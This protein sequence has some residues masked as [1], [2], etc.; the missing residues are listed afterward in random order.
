VFAEQLI[1]G[2]VLGSTYALIA[3]GYALQLSILRIF[4]LAYGDIMMASTFVGYL[5]LTQTGLGHIAAALA[6]ILTGAALGLVLER[7]TLRFLPTGNELSPLMVTI[8]VGTLLVSSF[9]LLFGFEWRA[10]PRSSTSGILSIGDVQ[11]T[12]IQILIL[13]I[14]FASMLGLHFMLSYTRYGRAIRA[15]S[16]RPHIAAA[17]GVNVPAVKTSAIALSSGMGGLAGILIAEN[18]GVV[19]AFFGTHFGLKGLIVVIIGGAASIWG[20]VV[21]GLA[22][23]MIEVFSAAYLFSE[24]RDAIAYAILIVVL[25][26]WPGGLA[27][28]AALR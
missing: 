10:F 14:I 28:R 2:L 9:S 20:A 13:V 3:V 12:S 27:P 4:N 15:T 11:I 17:F 23:G 24:Y 22:L 1:N 5:V 26:I 7:S 19:S 25:A 18:F 21:G 6:A 16:E 8:G